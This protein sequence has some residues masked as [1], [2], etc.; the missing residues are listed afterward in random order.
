MVAGRGGVNGPD[1]SS[2]G[3]QLTLRQLDQAQ[4]DLEAADE[5]IRGMKG[6]QEKAYSLVTSPAAKAA[7][8]ISKEPDKVRDS[9]GHTTFG[10][11]CLLAR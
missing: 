5:S 9:Y 8:D 6:Y 10:Q 4:R 1:L 11:S 7:F 2:I 3:Q